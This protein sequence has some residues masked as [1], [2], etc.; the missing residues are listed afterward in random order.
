VKVGRGIEP[1][2]ALLPRVWTWPAPSRPYRPSVTAKFYVPCFGAK[3]EA[4]ECSR[5]QPSGESANEHVAKDFP[6]P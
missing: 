5:N 4:D 6:W 1:H 2:V 3:T